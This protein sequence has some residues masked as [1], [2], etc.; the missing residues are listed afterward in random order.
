MKRVGEL[1]A[2]IRRLTENA[3]IDMANPKRGINTGDTPSIKRPVGQKVSSLADVSTYNVLDGQVL[4]WSQ[5]KQM[6]IPTTLPTYGTPIPEGIWSDTLV[7][8]NYIT[9]PAFTNGIDGWTLSYPLTDYT[10]DTPP[11]GYTWT[12]VAASVSAATGG[13][14]GDSCMKLVLSNTT[15]E[16]M[17]WVTF[18]L[19]GEG[20]GARIDAMIPPGG[21]GGESVYANVY[22]V[23][24]DGNDVLNGTSYDNVYIDNDGVWRTLYISAPRIADFP[25]AVGRRLVLRVGGNG[26]TTLAGMEVYF[27]KLASAQNSQDYFDGDPQGDEFTYEWTGTPHA[28]T[29]TRSTVKQINAP[30]TIT[31]GEPF[32]VRGRGFAPGVEVDVSEYDWYSANVLVTTDASGEFTT[33][34]TIPVNTDPDNGPVAGPGTIGAQVTGPYEYRPTLNVTFQ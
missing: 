17:N 30:A 15:M 32:T 6:W 24:A 25:G 7:D 27:D 12:N 19:P 8:L 3:G 1:E 13:N 31:M 21:L 28:S 20:F 23:D 2:I 14:R 29:S 16:Q 18:D 34:L 10:Y 11:I 5:Q 33:T 4:T 26:S 9:D 22:L